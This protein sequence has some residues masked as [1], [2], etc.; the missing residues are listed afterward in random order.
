M[1]APLLHKN[2]IIGGITGSGKTSFAK[3]I[4]ENAIKAGRDVHLMTQ[5]SEILPSE[6]TEYDDKAIC[7]LFPGSREREYIDTFYKVSQQ[8]FRENSFI[9]IDEFHPSLI[10]EDIFADFAIS[11]KDIN[12][13][14]IVVT[15]SLEI[16]IDLLSGF[17]YLAILK[18]FKN[19]F[20]NAQVE[21]IS[22]FDLEISINNLTWNFHKIKD[23]IEPLSLRTRIGEHLKVA[24]IDQSPQN[25]GLSHTSKA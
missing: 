5:D 25:K 2:I 17:A 20:Y 6:Y 19:Q 7:Y 14:I 12:S 3:Y 4:L 8:N 10:D 23:I 21:A 18:D 9:L 22:T 16:E 1:N 13:Q 15:Q 24:K 11:L